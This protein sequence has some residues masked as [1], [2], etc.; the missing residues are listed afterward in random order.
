MGEHSTE[1][2]SPHR[3]AVFVERAPFVVRAD[4]RPPAR[5]CACG[6]RYPCWVHPGLSV[7]P[8]LGLANRK[9][10]RSR[11]GAGDDQGDGDGE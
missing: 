3:A 4:T 5:C 8:W 1:R 9:W 2:K 11:R 10:P 6:R 7:A